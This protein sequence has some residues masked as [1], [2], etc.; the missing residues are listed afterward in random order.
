MKKI[1]IKL[2]FLVFLLAFHTSQATA[3]DFEVIKKRVIANL[4]EQNI[5]DKAVEMMVNT[6]NPDG[7]WSHIDYEDVSNEGFQ[8]S[9]HAANM[10]TMTRAYKK[11][12]SAFYPSST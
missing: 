4:L 5:Q 9:E 7:T 12:G 1:C 10:V 8:H 6:I 3:S 2:A 11:K